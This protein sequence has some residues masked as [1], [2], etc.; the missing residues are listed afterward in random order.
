MHFQNKT[1]LNIIPLF[2]RFRAIYT[3][4]KKVSLYIFIPVE[5]LCAQNNLLNRDPHAFSLIDTQLSEVSRGKTVLA[6][7]TLALIASELSS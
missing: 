7:T 6:V 4:T 2:Y 3:Q 1:I 5:V